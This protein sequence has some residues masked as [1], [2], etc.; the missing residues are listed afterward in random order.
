MLLSKNFLIMLLAFG[1]SVIALGESKEL[2]FKIEKIDSQK[3]L[4]K[5]VTWE[6]KGNL[7]SKQD[8]N[9]KLPLLPVNKYHATVVEHNNEVFVIGGANELNAKATAEVWSCPIQVSG[10][11]KIEWKKH[12]DLPY[13]AVFDP[14]ACSL[15]NELFIAGGINNQQEVVKK[16]VGYSEEPREGHIARA[17]ESRVDLPVGVSSFNAS[18]KVGQS[19]LLIAVEKK[20]LLFH[21]VTNTLLELEALDLLIPHGTMSVMG[22]ERKLI[23]DNGNEQFLITFDNKNQLLPILDYLVIAFYFVFVATVGVIFA[24]RQ[25][26]ANDFALGGQRI[27]WWAAAI[28]LMASGVSAISF[29]AIPAMIGCTSLVFSGAAFFI[30]PGIFVAAYI[31]YP[32]YR[33]LNITSTFEYL[34]NRYGLTLRLCGSALAIL[35]QIFARMS[36]VILLPALAISALTT[37]PTSICVLLIGI[38]TTLYSSA[39]GFEAVIWTDVLQGVLIFVGFILVGIIGY[40]NLPDG[41]NTIKETGLDADKFRLFIFNFDFA[42][43]VIWISIIGMIIQWMSFASDQVTAQ[44]ISCTP[45]RDVRKLSYLSGILGFAIAIFAGAIG[46]I[47]FAYYKTNPA[48]LDPFMK[49]DQMVPLFISKKV[50]VGITGLIIATLFAAS[51]STISTSVNTCAVLFGEDFVKRF[52]KNL[53]SKAELR[54]MQGMSIVAGT[55]GTFMAYYLISSKTPSIQQLNVE[56]GALFGGGFAGVFAL[57]MFTRRTHEYGAIVGILIS[58]LIPICLKFYFVGMLHWSVW[59]FAGVISCM[60]FGYLASWVIPCKKKDLTGLTIFDQIKIGK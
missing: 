16:S 3:E 36:I 38:I 28:S 5:A 27:K 30:L 57:G 52:K 31:T 21:D 32:L 12:P 34:E 54:C 51:M 17:Y 7:V 41:F 56:L 1:F 50:P 25:K 44:R 20:L 33:R 8:S 6:L 55:I 47:L 43:P 11:Q 40:I 37:I 48:V 22:S 14:L 45:L 4:T 24:R 18:S 42:L 35:L 58:A 23:L 9:I 49:N 60:V 26:N 59:G 29:M 2:G 46:V 39:G 10:K 53:S 13:G 15:Y 19:H